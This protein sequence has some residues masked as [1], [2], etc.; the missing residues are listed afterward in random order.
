MIQVFRID[1]RDVKIDAVELE[2]IRECVAARLAAETDDIY[3]QLEKE[4]RGSIAVVSPDDTRLGAWALTETDGQL[5]LVRIPPRGRVNHLFEAKL[6]REGGHWKVT[7]L[8]HKVMR[9]L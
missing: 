3:R 8:A 6:A 7:D 9:A 2:A 4:L 5:A 1:G